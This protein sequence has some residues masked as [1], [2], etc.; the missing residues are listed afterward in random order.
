MVTIGAVYAARQRMGRWVRRTP[1]EHSPLLSG[2]TGGEVWLKLE[3]RQLT[4][5]F[6]IRG[7]SNRIALLTPEERARG[8]VAASSGNHAQGVAY[9]AREL[10]VKAVIVVPGNTPKVKRDAIRALGADLTVH[11]G[12]Y[13][14][15]ERL[16]QAI[17]RERGLPFLSPYNDA[18]LIA[19]QGTVG[20]EMVEDGP[21]LDVVLVPVS[22]GGLISGI[23]TVMKA[24][25]KAEVI[26]VQTE[27]SPVMHE[28]VKA[29]K[30][31]D[32]PMFDTVAEGLHGGIEQGSVTFPICQKLVDDWIDVKEATIV[33][34]L[35]LMLLRHHE[36]VEGSGAVG[37]AALME[38]P[39]RFEGRR[40]GVIISGGN[41]DEEL[42][43]RLAQ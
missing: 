28:S 35:R 38:D 12:E 41:I 40:V 22:G 7:A 8:V 34:A 4:G 20:L 33:D 18:D 42:L 43:R 25:S 37:I 23:A 14:E 10:G 11:G 6:K 29:G 13:M 26:G 5:S 1:F 16:A 9:A 36:V 30:I 19:G 3:N 31:I 24:A 2:L 21:A 17:S 27:A 32:I 15:A 39:H